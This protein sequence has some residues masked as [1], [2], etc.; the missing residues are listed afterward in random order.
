MSQLSRLRS[1]I[2][3][4]PG[5]YAFAVAAAF[6]GATTYIGLVEQ[7][8]RARTRH[9]SMVRDWTEATGDGTLSCSRRL[10]ARTIAASGGDV[11]WR[12]TTILRAGHYACDVRLH[13]IFARQ[14]RLRRCAN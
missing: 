6:F 9:G 8:A 14:S 2:R 4:V 1:E 11:R 5:L 3:C 13:A 12:G 10:G 7:P